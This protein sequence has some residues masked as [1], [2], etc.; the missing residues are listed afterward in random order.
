M[1]G[2]RMEQGSRVSTDAVAAA[3]RLPFW[4]DVVCASFVELDC[5]SAVAAGFFGAIENRSLLDLQFSEVRSAAQRVTRSRAV[6]ARSDRDYFL[7]SL[8]TAG[9]G[10]VVQDGRTAL[11]QPGDFALYDTT[12]P[13][14]LNFAADFA[15]IVLRLPRE[16]VTRRLGDAG[17]LTALRVAGDRGTGRLAS[18]F[19]RQ[20]H[21]ELGRLGAASLG[22][23]QAGA[24]D[25][26]ATALAEQAGSDGLA[27]ADPKSLLRRRVEAYIE[28]R[29]GD[30]ALSCASVAAAQGI[31]A[32]Y[33]RRL[34]QEIDASVSELIWQ[35]RLEAAHRR[36]ADPRCAALP[37]TAIGYD[38]GFKDIAHFSRA[39][40]ARFGLSP[41]EHRARSIARA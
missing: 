21:G 11:L 23:L 9:S 16:A 38:A 29:L 10:V 8:Q 32:R 13:Y 24:I 12:R 20:L 28:G 25:L 40:R 35:R 14:D 3:V 30:P 26:L 6:I 36:L 22:S 39:F 2:A 15:Q 34:F 41:R 4:R 19:L 5:E 7:L 37:V 33:L 17:R 1:A 27:Q 18:G 31:S